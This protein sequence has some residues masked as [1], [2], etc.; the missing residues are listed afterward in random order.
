MSDHLKKTKTGVIWSFINQGGNQIISLLVTFILARLITP[1]EFG[2]IGMIAVFTNF[3][4]I[5]VDFGFSTALIQKKNMSKQD[6]DTVFFVNVISGSFL[7]ILFFVMAPLIADFYGEPDLEIFSRAISP[8]FLISSLSGVNKAITFKDLNIKLNSIITLTAT[9]ISSATAIT[10]AYYGFGVWSILSKMLVDQIAITILFLSFNPLSQSFSFNKSSFKGLFRFG[11]NVAGDAII[12]YWSRNADNLLIGKY[13]G[14]GSLGIY[15]KAYA[16]MMLPLRS[17]SGVIAKVMFPSF[18]HLQDDILQIRGIYLKSTK[19]I[20]F[21]TFP[22]M[23]GLAILAKPFVLVAFGENWVEMIPIISI[24]A[25]LG[26]IQSILS[27]NGVIYNSLGKSHIAFRVSIGMSIINI[28]AF[29]IGLKLGGLIGLVIAY[30]LAGIL[31]TLPNFYM[32]GKQIRVSILDMLKNLSNAFF[33]AGSMAAGIIILKTYI[34]NPIG[35][36]PV[37]NLIILSI[38]GA[39]LYFFIAYIFKFEEIQ[40]AKRLLKKEKINDV[41]K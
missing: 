34:I 4:V 39:A 12:N 2:I 28:T 38:F 31:T 29:I 23:T 14:E 33:C 21:I 10:M 16:V 20:A 25:L 22:M 15:T 32:A 36:S 3:A 18:S 35:L 13:L 41:E 27:L 9:L 7:S 24:L 40:L 1:E 30:A 11:S 19:L 17:I 37:F 6:I 5:F 26:A 8:I